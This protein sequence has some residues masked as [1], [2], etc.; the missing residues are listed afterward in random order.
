MFRYEEGVVSEA[1]NN[2][3][4]SNYFDGLDWGKYTQGKNFVFFQ[5][6]AHCYG[7]HVVIFNLNA[8]G[9]THLEGI[10]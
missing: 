6:C 4:F 5:A 9:L 3:R 1:E 7:D 2:F 8:R 10:I